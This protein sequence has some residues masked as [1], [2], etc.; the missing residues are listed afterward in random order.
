VVTTLGVPLS[1]PFLDL[2]G[3]AQALATPP[4]KPKKRPN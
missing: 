4:I 2:E 1:T 3:R